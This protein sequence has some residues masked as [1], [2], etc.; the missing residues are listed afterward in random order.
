MFKRESSRIWEA[1][2]QQQLSV[3]LHL[4]ETN[5]SLVVDCCLG[6]PI[7]GDFQLYS[8]QPLSHQR[9]LKYLVP[10]VPGTSCSCVEVGDMVHPLNF[11]QDVH[12][13]LNR[14][15]ITKFWALIF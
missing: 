6:H 3:C 10:N 14:N 2:K 4:D 13:R 7:S 5:K 8:K 9:D 1:S 12:M 11:V 15:E